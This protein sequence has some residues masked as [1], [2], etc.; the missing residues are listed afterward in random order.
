MRRKEK[1]HRQYSPP[2]SI[3]AS[4]IY[5]VN[6][7]PTAIRRH[8]ESSIRRYHRREP[9]CESDPV[10]KS[11]VKRRSTFPAEPRPERSPSSASVSGSS[12]RSERRRPSASNRGGRSI[13]S[14]DESD[15]GDRA[16]VRFACVSSLPRRYRASR[17]RSSSSSSSYPMSLV[18]G[19]LRGFTASGV[20]SADEGRSNWTV[21]SRAGDVARGV[22]SPEDGITVSAP[23]PSEREVVSAHAR[24]TGAWD[25]STHQ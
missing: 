7:T 18:P 20:V 10:S 6:R 11:C 9:D 3:L 14:P 8:E 19:R 23:I 12:P 24:A 17:A 2:K 22:T 25:G 21:F 13:V 4:V 1:K 15:P 16:R 5:G